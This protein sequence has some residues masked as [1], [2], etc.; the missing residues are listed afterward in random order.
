MNDLPCNPMTDDA[1]IG[2][3]GEVMTN[4]ERN[5]KLQELAKNNGLDVKNTIQFTE[6]T[7]NNIAVAVVSL[8]LAKRTGDPDYSTLVRAGMQHRK[9]KSDVINKYKDQANQLIDRYKTS[10]REDLGSI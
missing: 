8:Y 6:D 3:V 4:L 9:L 10:I 2:K 7:I 5:R 1:I